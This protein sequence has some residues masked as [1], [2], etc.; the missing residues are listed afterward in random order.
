MKQRKK[1]G[2]KIIIL[3]SIIVASLFMSIGY[4][5][6]SQ[7]IQLEGKASLK[8]AEKY[9]WH[10]IT[11]DYISSSGSGFYENSTE[12]KKYSYIGNGDSNNIKIG[13]DIWKII[14]IEKDHTIKIAKLDEKIKKEFDEVNNRTSNSTYCTDLTNGCNAWSIKEEL[15][16]DQI[17]GNVENDST[18]LTY[19]NGDYYTS[20][21]D[22]LKNVIVEHSFNIGSIKNEASYSEILVQESEYT[23]TGKIGLLTVSEFLYP[24][25]LNTPTSNLTLTSS[26]NNN[27][28]IN[29]ASDKFLWTAN[30]LS[31]NSSNVWTVTKDLTF[32]PKAANLNTETIDE[33]SYD[34]IAIPT[35]YLNSTV[36]YLE[37]D[38]SSSNP[39]T[40]K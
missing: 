12:S 13:N 30:A 3:S 8:A 11:T 16:N 15:I 32:T 24:S 6:L 36:E 9:L 37:G 28:L 21:N 22:E 18:I 27:Y 31:N 26:Y 1:R 34:Y 29:Y 38:G 23:W 10:K 20:L 39:F 4:S 14:S 25:T 2:K 19:L 35:T 33:V 40:I 7:K 5:I 17:S